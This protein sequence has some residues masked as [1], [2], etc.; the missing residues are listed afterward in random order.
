MVLLSRISAIF[1]GV[2]V[3]EALPCTAGSDAARGARQRTAAGN[4]AR[5]REHRH[6]ASAAEQE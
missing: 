4:G 6:A 2:A 1:D 3:R 5:D